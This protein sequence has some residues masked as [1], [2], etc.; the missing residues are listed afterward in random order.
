MKSLFRLV[1]LFLL[2]SGW[3][4]AAAS[5]HVVVSP[6]HLPVFIPKDR[7]GFHDTYVDT[8]NW[9]L[10]DIRAHRDVVLRIAQV[11]KVDLL[12][13]AFDPSKGTLQSQLGDIITAPQAQAQSGTVDA[14]VSEKLNDGVHAATDVVKSVFD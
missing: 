8:R 11:G 3:G 10:A 4:L 6:N 1:T 14:I 12:S 9:T 2:L 5:L 13:H 7:M